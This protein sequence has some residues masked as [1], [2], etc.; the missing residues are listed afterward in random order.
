MGHSVQVPAK[1]GAF[2]CF[3]ASKYRQ[4]VRS[5][6]AM[7]PALQKNRGIPATS[8]QSCGRFQASLLAFNQGF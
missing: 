2:A 3:G 5:P 6:C 7:Q 8:R 1:V 4:D